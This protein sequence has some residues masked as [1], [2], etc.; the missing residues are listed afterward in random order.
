MDT[1]TRGAIDRYLE[2]HRRFAS[3]GASTDPS[4]LKA[5]RHRAI[6][7]FGQTGF[8][9]TQ[10]E[11]WRFTNVS[12]LTKDVFGV[13]PPDRGQ[14]VRVDDL[15]DGLL[16]DRWHRLVLVDGRCVAGLS[17]T[18]E[19][20]GTCWIGSF[21]DALEGVHARVIEQHL[22]RYAA[23]ENEPFAALCTAF[24]HDGALLY[25]AADT[26]LDTPLHV[27]NV[28]TGQ[29]GQ[30][31]HPRLLVVA[32]QGA[33][34]TIVESYLS[35][36][37]EGYWT[38]AVTEGVIGDGARVEWYRIQREESSAFHIGTTQIYQGRDSRWLSCSVALGAGLSRH[39]LRTEL[40]G[41]GAHSSLDGVYLIDGARHVDHHTTI[42][43]ARPH[44]TS[45]ELFNGVLD[46]EARAVFTGRIIVRPGA[47]RTD[48]KQSNNNMLLTENARADSQP[49]LEIYADDVRC[50]HGATLGP[51]DEKSLFYL[52]SRGIGRSQ[53]RQMLTYGF[54][55]EVLREIES[56][57]LRSELDR[58]IRRELGMGG[59]AAV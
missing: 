20:P 46:D 39:D 2:A 1:H 27:I 56:Q 26:T 12:G 23:V 9:T 37:G 11:A 47:Q 28:S 33:E 10:H 42:D 29:P 17:Q 35:L 5:M 50:T 59:L 19:L 22:A 43:H 54:A 3:N 32:E 15:T 21:R 52:E 57:T 14:A 41:E 31:S 8:P 34:A 40:A 30:V 4:W 48:S 24:I 13:T 45:H 44:C 18:A 6:D 7:A 55:A 36:G 49:Q 58:L 25:I 53:A 38:N 16:D 51:I